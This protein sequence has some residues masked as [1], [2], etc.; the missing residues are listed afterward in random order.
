MPH[1][2]PLLVRIFR[3]DPLLYQEILLFTQT[4]YIYYLFIYLYFYLPIK[5]YQILE[6]EL[7]VYHGEQRHEN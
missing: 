2:H 7:T 1:S 5:N 6:Q 3:S 4:E